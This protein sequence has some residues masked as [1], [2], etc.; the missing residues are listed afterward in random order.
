MLY[1]RAYGDIYHRVS[2]VFGRG[3]EEIDFLQQQGIQVKVI[4]GMI[5]H[6]SFIL[7]PSLDSQREHIWLSRNL[8]DDSHLRES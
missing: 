4:P 1:S 5:V 2:K 6:I 7:L 3:G 8:E